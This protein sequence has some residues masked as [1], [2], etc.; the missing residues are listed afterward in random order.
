MYR[1]S[2]RFYLL[3][4][5]HTTPAL[6]NTHGCFGKSAYNQVGM[7]RGPG[8]GMVGGPGE[9]LMEDGCVEKSEACMMVLVVLLVSSGQL[10]VRQ[11][12]G[13]KPVI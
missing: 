13:L 5:M 7:G 6:A 4:Q 8:E 2:R 12:G 9:G 3:F 11:H 1:T 10:D